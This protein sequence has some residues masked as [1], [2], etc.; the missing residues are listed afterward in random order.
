M[1]EKN[2]YVE[3]AKRKIALLSYRLESAQ[4]KIK[5]LEYDNAELEG[6][7]QNI[8]I[9]RLKELSNEFYSRYHSKKYKSR[10]WENEIYTAKR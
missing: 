5:K 3:D 10:N 4:Y 9:P 7:V 1:V 6:W 8:C 2:N